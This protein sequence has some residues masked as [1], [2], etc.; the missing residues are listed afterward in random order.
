MLVLLSMSGC[1]VHLRPLQHRKLHLLQP[2]PSR[3]ARS[4]TPLGPQELLPALGK[5]LVQGGAPA[6]WQV[7]PVPQ[8]VPL[9]PGPGG[10]F[11]TPG[12]RPLQPLELETLCDLLV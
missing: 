12:P 9:H 6:G 1:R 11:L 3:G 10:G 2:S 5:T 8:N 7:L 4:D